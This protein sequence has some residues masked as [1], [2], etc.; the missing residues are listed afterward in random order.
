MAE[1]AAHITSGG[2]LDPNRPSIFEVLAQQ[3][4]MST[5]RPAIQHAIRVI[6]ERYPAQMGKILQYYDELFLLFDAFI[7]SYFLKTCGGSFAENFYDLKRVPSSS[8]KSSSLSLRLRMRVTACLVLVP[9]VRQKMDRLFEDLQYKYGQDLD[10]FSFLQENLSLRQRLL[11]LYLSI[12]PYIHT[13]WEVVTLTYILSYML[14][15]GRWH[16]PTVHLSGT[17]LCRINPDDEKQDSAFVTDFSTWSQLGLS[18]KILAALR[19]VLKLTAACVTTSLSVGVFFLQFLEWWYASDSSAPSLTAL[20]IPPA[21]KQEKLE[22][23]SHK[24]CPLCMGPRS[25]STALSVSGYVFCY[26]CIV[27]HVRR[28][29]CC[30]I[31]GY[32]ASSEHLVKIYEQDL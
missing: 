3:S 15:E 21:P 23:V 17:R 20:P 2:P 22:G 24:V 16:C 18:G 30:P 8:T 12:Y 1:H 28:E 7:Q 13:G 5:I 31:T 29:K 11:R 26:P 6:A 14:H 4:L 9:Y 19:V 27:E 25:N 32:P 10:F